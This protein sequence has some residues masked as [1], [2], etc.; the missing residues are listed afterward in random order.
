MQHFHFEE[1]ILTYSEPNITESPKFNTSQ[2]E[3]QK[4]PSLKA[5][6]NSKNNAGRSNPFLDPINHEVNLSMTNIF[7]IQ[8]NL[9][10]LSKPRH[11]NEMKN[12][13]EVT[14]DLVRFTCMIMVMNM[15][16]VF[17]HTMTSKVFTDKESKKY[18]MTG[19]HATWLQLALYLPDV[20][21]FIGGYLAASSI[22]RM[23]QVLRRKDFLNY[24]SFKRKNLN[25]KL[26]TAKEVN[27][28]LKQEEE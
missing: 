23:I 21:L 5:L 17:L 15:S 2:P 3:T 11:Q 10:R 6:I 26:V 24:V 27:E 22:Y 16:M 14:I 20:F 4:I 25:K 9:R 1:D 13:F 12:A 28:E 7:S 19:L 8:S 18:Y